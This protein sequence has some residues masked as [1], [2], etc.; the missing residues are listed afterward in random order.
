MVLALL[1]GCRCNPLP[2]GQ[3][4]VFDTHA[5]QQVG[6]HFYDQS[7]APLAPAVAF[8]VEARCPS[9]ERATLRAVTP[10]LHHL[11]LRGRGLGAVERISAALFDGTLAN[12]QFERVGDTLEMPIAC[13]RCEIYLGVEAGDRVAACI[14]PGHSIAIAGG[15]I[16]P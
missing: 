16:L 11:T 10:G 9:L 1:F 7:D 6:G 15:Q 14:G 12:V 4:I 5:I 2:P 3:D 13:N 8:A